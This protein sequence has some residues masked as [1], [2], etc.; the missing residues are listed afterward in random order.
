MSLLNNSLEGLINSQVIKSPVKSNQ[1]GSAV[2]TNY[3]EKN[4]LK[5]SVS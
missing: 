4:Q 2:K 5:E 3:A 1:D